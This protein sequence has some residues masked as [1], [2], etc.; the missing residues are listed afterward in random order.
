MPLEA[1]R[2]AADQAINAHIVPVG[3]AKK[4]AYAPLRRAGLIF[5]ISA[6]RDLPRGR[7]LLFGYPEREAGEAH[8]ATDRI[9]KDAQLR[10]SDRLLYEQAL[11]GR[12]ERYAVGIHWGLL[13]WLC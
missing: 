6:Q 3:K 11:L 10:F 13:S 1:G 7:G 12:N 8:P 9:P 2:M 5:T 4:G